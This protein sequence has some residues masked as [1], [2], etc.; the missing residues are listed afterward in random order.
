MNNSV[1]D[2]LRSRSA[3]AFALITLF[4][5]LGAA[6]GDIKNLVSDLYSGDGISLSTTP[7]SGPGG[8]FRASHAPHFTADSLRGLDNLNNAVTNSV[9]NIPFNSTVSGYT[10][11]VKKGA[12]VRRTESLGPLL[13]ERAPTIGKGILNVAFSY[14]HVDFD[15]FN[16]DNLNNLRLDF[17][18]DDCCGGGGGGFAPPPDGVRGTPDFERD[19]VGVNVDLDIQ[20]DIY[21]LSGTFGL[22]DRWD[23]GAVIPVISIKASATGTAFIEDNGGQG[24]HSFD[25]AADTDV[26]R[27]GDNRVGIGDIILRSKYNFTP[28]GA[29]WPDLALVG[30]VTLP[31]GDEDDLLGTGGAKFRFLFVAS[32][33]FNW[34]T[35]HVNL[36]YEV[37][38][39]NSE[40]DNF[41]YVAGIDAHFGEYFT[42]AVDIIGKWNPDEL[43]DQNNLIDIALQGK[44]NVFGRATLNAFVILP[45]N[46]NEGLRDNATWSVGF[47]HTFF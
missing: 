8:A 19:V 41:R 35:P 23:I 22:T 44:W 2:V 47:E 13:A 46:R 20:Q 18:H 11:D 12:P 28:D 4:Q 38:T 15:R 34:I 36:G 30:G 39:G 26:S 27:I 21:A 40:E 43:G 14:V 32:E 3:Q 9:G 25:D 7:G 17:L 37:T 10:Y 29:G 6:A 42:S 24:L 33:Q 16:G 5:P 1:M 45:L 31:T